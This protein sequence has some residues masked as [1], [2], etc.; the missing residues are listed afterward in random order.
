MTNAGSPSPLPTENKAISPIKSQSASE[1]GSRS[2]H[3][4]EDE[5]DGTDST[6]T[7]ARSPTPLPAAKKASSSSKVESTSAPD[8]SRDEETSGSGSDSSDDGKSEDNE[9]NKNGNINSNVSKAMPLSPV[10]QYATKEETVSS[11]LRA[12]ENSRLP[13]LSRPAFRSME[14]VDNSLASER[15]A[16]GPEI[17]CQCIKY[18]QSNPDHCCTRPSAQLK[19][20][21]C[22]RLNKP[23]QSIPLHYRAAAQNLIE[24]PRDNDFES[25]VARL[26]N[27]LRV[28]F[29]RRGRRRMPD[30]DNSRAAW[31]INR[32]LFR[33]VNTLRTREFWQLLPAGEEEVEEGFFSG[34]I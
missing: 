11:T 32:N 6:V 7:L 25:R 33:L 18:L 8:A 19:C 22:A 10:P 16:K 24:N 3:Y 27:D 30:N 5:N 29:R 4:E 26:N 14:S 31:S 13:A 17:C 28:Y 20:D 12:L 21:N 23:C 2:E 9:E 15:G 1:S 34:R